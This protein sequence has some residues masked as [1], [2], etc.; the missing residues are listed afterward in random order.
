M[1]AYPG[2]SD[3]II[4]RLKRLDINIPVVGDGVVISLNDKTLGEGSWCVDDGAP[5]LSF[6]EKMGTESTLYGE[7]LYTEMQIIANAFENTPLK[8]NTKAD[9]LSV[10]QTL[11]NKTSGLETPLG[12]IDMNDQGE[13][14]VPAVYKEIKDG[15]VQRM[16]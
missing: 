14:F 3:L 4:T 10:I 9:M 16:E 15:K 11:K 1:N 6:I 13:I 5:N 2:I 8:N 12:I 7:F